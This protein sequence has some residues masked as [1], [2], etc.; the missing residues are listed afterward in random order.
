[1]AI[2][3]HT[4]THAAHAGT[5]FVPPLSPGLAPGRPSTSSM[6]S[7]HDSFTVV[8]T[9]DDE[10]DPEDAC[11]PEY[12]FLSVDPCSFMSRP[13]VPHNKSSA[14]VSSLSS[15]SSAPPTA[16]ASALQQAQ[17]QSVRSYSPNH[18]HSSL[19]CP[20]APTHPLPPPPSQHPYGAQ[21]T[22]SYS[23]Y[24][25]Y[26]HGLPVSPTSSA[27]TASSPTSP[28]SGPP[29]IVYS[30]FKHADQRARTVPPRR[31]LPSAPV[32][33][34]PETPRHGLPNLPP[35]PPTPS[36]P[37][38]N[39]GQ[40][41]TMTHTPAP[42]SRHQG[43][44][45]PYSPHS[46]HSGGLAPGG[47][48]ASLADSLSS[49]GTCESGTTLIDSSPTLPTVPSMTNVTRAGSVCGKSVSGKSERGFETRP[50]T[51]TTASS[52]ASIATGITTG[53]GGLPREAQPFKADRPW[54]K[55]VFH[56]ASAADVASLVLQGWPESDARTA[57]SLC[58]T[59]D[60]AIE[61]LTLQ[62]TKHY[63]IATLIQDGYSPKAVR[64]AVDKYPNADVANA[65]LMHQKHC[66]LARF[67]PVKDCM[68][69]DAIVQCRRNL[70]MNDSRVIG[71]GMGTPIGYG[72]SY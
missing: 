46:P 55:R 63:S 72:F 22:A 14:S 36:T 32:P 47:V 21:S 25:A 27:G 50:S 37:E 34:S 20:S 33:P 60:K 5:M 12:A 13:P 6:S 58:Q 2:Y 65:Y 30:A 3:A 66:D 9:A 41:V 7:K 26:G 23:N 31:P 70:G 64:E 38:Y 39:H 42:G 67:K 57:L 40:Q 16:S 51:P 61:Y 45:T 54:L 4:A 53:V 24:S 71:A 48:R 10:E 8:R 15:C 56:K 17:A 19:P 59:T 68:W 35:L 49:K 18:Q 69:C 62:R 11:R 43:P 29:I 28:T 1:M 52:G 44:H